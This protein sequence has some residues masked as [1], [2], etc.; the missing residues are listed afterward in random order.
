MGNLLRAPRRSPPPVLP[1]PVPATLPGHDGSGD[2]SPAR[3][4]NDTRQSL[5]HVAPQRRLG[6]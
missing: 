6:R 2:S 3:D 1:R 4:G 5:L